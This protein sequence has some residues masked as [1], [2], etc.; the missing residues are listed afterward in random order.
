[1]SIELVSPAPQTDFGRGPHWLHES[2]FLPVDWDWKPT[3]R[4]VAS[5]KQMAMKR[6]LA[7]QSALKVA[8]FKSIPW[9]IAKWMWE[10]LRQ[11]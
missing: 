2:P 9:P 8:H 1:M 10:S 5:L 11:P 4:T 3:S 7:D 6:V